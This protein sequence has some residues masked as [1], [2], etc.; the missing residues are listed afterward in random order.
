[1]NQP[2]T[3]LSASRQ[4]SAPDSPDILA[5]FRRYLWFTIAG[6]LVG[7]V[8]GSVIWGWLRYFH[9]KWSASVSFQVLPPQV[10]L[11]SKLDQSQYDNDTQEEVAQFIQRQLR[12]IKSDD[13]LQKSL[14]QDAFQRDPVTNQPTHWMME[15]PDH[16]KDYLK[17]DLAV[18]PFVNA[19]VFQL[20]MTASDASEAARLV[21]T[22]ARVYQD[23]LRADNNVNQSEQQAQ[24]AK[25]VNDQRNTVMTAQSALDEF[26]KTYNISAIINLH[27]MEL[28]LLQDMDQQLLKDQADAAALKSAQDSIIDHLAKGNLEVSSDMKQWVEGQP[29]MVNLQ[30]TLI[31]LEQDRQVAMKLQGANT[32]D[33]AAI[34]ARK[35]AVTQQIQDTRAM[36]ED[37][38]RHRMAERAQTEY[39]SEQAEVAYLM[40]AKTQEEN[41]VK[42]LDHWLVKDQ[43][44]E[45]DLEN[46]QHILDDLTQKLTFAQLSSNTDDLRIRKFGGDA[47]PPDDISAPIW[48]WP[49]IPAGCILGFAAAYGLAYLFESTNTRVRTPQDIT[50]T[51]QLP[52]LGFVPDREDDSAL[53]GSLATSIR[54]APT[55][56]IAESFRQIR[57][58]LAAQANGSPFKSLLVASISPGGGATT[59]ASNLANGMALNK[60]KI[61][62]VDANFYQPGLQMEYRNIPAVGLSDVISDP[63]KLDSAIAFNPELPNLHLMGAGGRPAAAAGEI[64][65]GKAF[66]E[67]LDML[68]SRYDLVIFDGAPLN[69][70]SDSIS[71]AARVDGVIAVVRAGEVSRGTVVRIREQLR[72]VKANLLGVVLNA[73]QTHNAGYFKEN[74]RTFYEYANRAPR[75]TATT[76]A[77]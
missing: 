13:V 30:Q 41:K 10:G 26:R 77:N 44:M 18:E 55:S 32:R 21:N 70:V 72:Q 75:P 24:L 50:R 46:Q 22:I 43:Q 45:K 31:Q 35:V 3:T 49:Y 67:L 16:R 20:T 34:D 71:L 76:A 74:Y 25:A 52:L 47:V 56:M 23:A 40:D 60:K 61:L 66:H 58:H 39:A 29:Q 9:P 4:P 8:I 19:G 2:S 12:Y 28:N 5:V 7:T 57:S 27:T 42:D 59:V 37:E 38:A 14:D 15:H 36:L 73:A 33:L 53:S 64:M 11:A 69:L 1:M 48:Y 51:I 17:K 6:A 68:K 54:T 62:L 63:T 65:E